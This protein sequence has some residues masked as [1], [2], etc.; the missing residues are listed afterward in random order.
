MKNTLTV[1]RNCFILILFLVGC[2]PNRHSL[3]F[4]QDQMDEIM[5][6]PEVRWMNF[7]PTGRWAILNHGWFSNANELTLIDIET[8]TE[9][10]VSL[11]IP[12]EGYCDKPSF[13]PRED[14]LILICQTK[15]GLW[16]DD[17]LIRLDLTDAR[18]I[19]L[20]VLDTQLELG[21]WDIVWD[22]TGDRFCV[23]TTNDEILI[24]ERTEVIK[25]VQ[26]GDTDGFLPIFVNGTIYL[27]IRTYI[28]DTDDSGHY[29]RTVYSLSEP[30]DLPLVAIF[31]YES[32]HGYYFRTDSR[33]K[34]IVIP[35]NDPT[36]EGDGRL[37]FTVIS[38]RDGRVVRQVAS[39]LLGQALFF[40]GK[41]HLFFYQI[42]EKDEGRIDNR[43]HAMSWRNFQFTSQEKPVEM[44]LTETSLLEDW[45]ELYQ[46]IPVWIETETYTGYRLVNFEK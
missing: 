42:N 34:Y 29:S 32:D 39:P 16:R 3:S 25:H 14:T 13:S 40:Q 4:Y 43:L 35:W 10:T 5:S 26:L 8:Q 27:D 36:P 19:V 1:L 18:A 17:F 45:K 33:N 11:P 46:A 24:Y 12:E 9:V 38:A 6:R 30:Y 31:T 44:S 21:R 23:Y 28:S 20:V 22:S 2:A 15:G 37:M 7:S 41:D